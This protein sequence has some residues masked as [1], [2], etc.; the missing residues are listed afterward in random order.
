MT[1]PAVVD[2]IAR[3]LVAAV[4]AWDYATDRVLDPDKV[5]VTVASWPDTDGAA[6]VVSTYSGGPEPDS[7]NGWEY[8]RLQVKVRDA[9]PLAALALDR[10]AFAALQFRTDG[11]GP[12]VLPGAV[13]FL[14]DCYA[15][16]SEAQPLGQDTNGRHEFVRNYQLTAY[17]V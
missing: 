6:V 12:G 14:Q 13:W 1:S 7:R 5:P 15:L 16:Q 3:L 9:D 11:V 10:L 17:P 8:P 4:P 2:G